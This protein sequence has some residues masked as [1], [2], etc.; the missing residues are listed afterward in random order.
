MRRERSLRANDSIVERFGVAG[1]VPGAKIHLP[2]AS[3]GCDGLSRQM[4]E[5]WDD[6]CPLKTKKQTFN[7]Q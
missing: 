2:D 6:A 3:R 4:P 7:V 1:P 5:V